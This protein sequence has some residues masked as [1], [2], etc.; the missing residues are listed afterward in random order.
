MARIRNLAPPLDAPPLGAEQASI[1]FDYG[2]QLG[3]NIITEVLEVRIFV[4]GGNDPNPQG[5]LIGSP[6]VIASPLTGIAETAVRQVFGGMPSDARYGLQC[7]IQSVSG[8]HLCSDR[9]LPARRPFAA[10]GV[11]VGSQSFPG[12]NVGQVQ[13]KADSVNFGGFD[14]SGDATLNTSTGVLTLAPVTYAKLQPA[15][16]TGRFL[17]RISAGAGTIEEL[18][19]GNAWTVLGP[20]PA[21]NHPALI[22]DVTTGAGSLTTV[23]GNAVVT[24]AKMQPTTGTSVLLGRGSSGPGT[25][26]EIGIGAGLT[27]TGTTLAGTGLSDGA[28]GDITVSGSGTVWTINAGVV[29]NAKLANMTAPAFKG[30]T[31]A[32]SGAPEDLTSAQ[33]T[34]LLNVFTP[35]LPGLAPASGG[36]TVNFL[37]ADGAYAAPSVTDANRGDI[38]TSSG[39]TVWTVNAN[40]ITYGKLQATAAGAILLGRGTVGGGGTVQEIALGTNLTMSGTTL[41]A[42]GT[43]SSTLAFGT[44]AVSG[45]SNVVAAISPDTLN[46]AAGA[47]VTLTTNA[48][49]KTVTITSSGGTAA[50]GG[51]VGQ[52]QFNNSGALGGF[53]VGGDATLNTTS[54]VLTIGNAKIT[55]AKMQHTAA[56]SVLLGRGAGAG[57]GSLQELVLGSGLTMSGTTLNSAGVPGGTSG[58]SQYNNAGAFGGYTMSGDATLVTSTGV[59]TISA[60]AVTYAKMQ[61]VSSVSVLLG[62]GSAS[63]G[64]PQ[65]ITLGTG[66]SMSGTTLSASGG[67]PGGSTG[68]VQYNNTGALGGFT[69]GG[70]ATLVTSTGV[71]TIASQAVTYGKMQN[72]SA[73]SLLLG[74]GSTGAGSPQEITLGSGLSM[75]GTTL[76]SSASATPGGAN[77]QVQFNDTGVIAG[78]ADLTWDKTNNVLAI[79]SGGTGKLRVGSQSNVYAFDAKAQI[80]GTD[81]PSSM[82]VLA[83]FQPTTVGPTLV[84]AKSSNSVIGAHSAVQFNDQLGILEI[85]GSNGTSFQAGALL[86]CYADDIWSSGYTPARWDLSTNDGGS[87]NG[88][89]R[90]DSSGHKIFASNNMPMQAS[91]PGGYGIEYQVQQHGNDFPTSGYAIFNWHDSNDGPYHIW[92]KSRGTPGGPKIVQNG[93]FIGGYF[94]MGDDGV[95][96]REAAKLEVRVSGTPVTGTAVPSQ[97]GFIVHNTSGPLQPLMIFPSGEVRH[98]YSITEGVAT[99][100]DGATVAL[101]ASQGQQFKLVAAGDR[102]I[103]APTNAPITAHSQRIVIIHKASGANRTLTLTTGSAGAFRFGATITGLTTTTSGTSDY[104]TAIWNELDSRWDVVAYVKGF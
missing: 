49:T 1:I 96:L 63:T 78:D 81:F 32:G 34:A 26:Q 58:Q 95:N 35:S 73:A 66:L 31:S 8:E 101:D 16:A 13:Y 45:Q 42:S 104:I 39:G 12:G 92:H 74:R 48:G 57:A 36:G 11:S 15:S 64:S 100:T 50:P 70:D 40:A 84:L 76:S 41:N 94:F 80:V 17:G 29:S 28:K 43:G 60:Q 21:A 89:I 7:V 22:G 65:E 82:M 97:F 25:L 19:P 3:D 79:S 10:L 5:R 18:T 56:A 62:R 52:V 37:R 44:V 33:A 72:I 14:V 51:G 77:T 6:Q 91:M 103:L 53:D 38:T 71:L 68:Q 27:M 23:I 54:G 98:D 75:S 67:I 61:N 83:R 55:Y 2:P 9:V 4:L 24:Y 47:N 86:E 59:V 20:M 69:V 88:R 99:L 87:M 93:D 90:I 102:T 30:R 46:L 85:D